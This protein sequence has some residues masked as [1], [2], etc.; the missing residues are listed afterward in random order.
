M[1]VGDALAV[2]ATPGTN[3]L[4]VTVGGDAPK[5]TRSLICLARAE[6]QKL[7]TQTL[8]AIEPPG[9]VSKERFDEIIGV[10]IQLIGP[11]C[12]RVKRSPEGVGVV[13]DDPGRA[14]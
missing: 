14:R 7:I 9:V 12:P 13:R 4:A 1:S 10:H 11:K 8:I 6:N 2:S 5:G 3:H